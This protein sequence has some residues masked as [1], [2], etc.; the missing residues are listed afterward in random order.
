MRSALPWHLPGLAGLG[1]A[2]ALGCGG[3]DLTLPGDGRPAQLAVVTG[4]EQTGAPGQPLPQPLVVR[5]TDAAQAPVSQVRIA[6]VVTAGGGHTVPDTATTDADGRASAQW[7]L[8]TSMGAQAVEARVVGSD[9]VRATFL[10]TATP[11]GGPVPAAS[12]TQI[13]GA[14]PS[15]SFP[16]QPVTVAF[17]VSAQS[18]TP[19]G[20]VTV[21]DGAVSCTAS[22]PAGQ[23]S[24]TLATTGSR[25]LT[26]SYAGSASFTPSSG[27]ATHEV[28]RAGTS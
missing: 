22:A 12:T 6:F 5:A 14:N 16:T 20:T 21:T 15:P 4:N 3:S 8:G 28:V 25:T 17:R 13:T 2:L 10:G 24:L 11:G 18:G 26:A 19:T 23:C 9:P 1:A 27:T 7:T